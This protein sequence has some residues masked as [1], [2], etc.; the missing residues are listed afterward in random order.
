MLSVFNI[1]FIDNWSKLFFTMWLTLTNLLR[2]HSR[3]QKIWDWHFVVVD[4][5][6]RTKIYVLWHDICILNIPPPLP[7]LPNL[8]GAVE[9]MCISAQ[10]KPL[11]STRF[12]P[13]LPP[14]SSQTRHLESPYCILSTDFST[15]P[16]IRSPTW[17]NIIL[18]ILVLCGYGQHKWLYDNLLEFH[19][20][21]N[22]K[23]I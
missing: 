14:F 9:C 19:P 20:W 12:N 16:G 7:S 15:V 23:Y 4:P 17:I 11:A 22:Y 18:V 6:N 10:A 8:P 1:Y 13:K 5:L 21:R 2:I 3:P